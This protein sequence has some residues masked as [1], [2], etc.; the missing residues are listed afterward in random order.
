MC[1]LLIDC[2]L[3]FKM[4]NTRLE[5]LKRLPKVELHAHLNGS[6]SQNTICKLAGSVVEQIISWLDFGEKY[7]YN[8]QTEL[9]GC[10]PPDFQIKEGEAIDLANVFDVFKAVQGSESIL[11]YLSIINSKQLAFWFWKTELTD[12]PE[13]VELAAFLTASEFAEDGVRYLELRSGSATGPGTSSPRPAPI[14]PSSPV[15]FF[16][17]FL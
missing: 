14:G 16:W 17:K 3:L 5:E 11:F 2:R 9:K 12:S 10:R 7:L 15:F 13:L 1:V 6:L 4:T 8:R